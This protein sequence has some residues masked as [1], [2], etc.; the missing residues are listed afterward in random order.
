MFAPSANTR[1]RRALWAVALAGLALALALIV[2]SPL[3]GGS[4]PLAANTAALYQPERA[5]LPVRLKIPKIKVDAVVEHVG[6]T[7]DGAMDA[8][9]GP[10]TTGWYDRG[11]RPGETGSAVIDGH[12]DSVNGGPAV[13]DSLHT[14][15]AGDRL[16]VQDANGATTTFVVHGFRTYTPNEDAASVFISRDER[17]H[18]NLI[19]CMGVWDRAQQSYS[20]RLVVFADREMQFEPNEFGVISVR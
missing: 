11:P 2:W 16:S 3:Q 14:L 20:N 5:G 18:L 15:Q 7:P 6:L 12:F 10:T 17:A 1:S 9:A 8:P 4:A 19:T 13:F